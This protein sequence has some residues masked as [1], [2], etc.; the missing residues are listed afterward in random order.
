MTDVLDA[1]AAGL[2]EIARAEGNLDRVKHE[3]LD[4]ADQVETHES[5]RTVLTDELVPAARRQAIAEELLGGRAHQQTANVVSFV[6]GAG[7]AEDLVEIA[8]R[9][10]VRAAEGADATFAEVRSATP[11]SADQ[12]ARLAA[13]LSEKVGKKLDLRVVVD[14]SVVGG[15][16]ATIGDQVF[17]GS[18]RTKL[19]QLKT[20]L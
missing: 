14:P 11:L 15:L 19:D 9:M 6:I 4:V 8:R 5:L 17:D 2:V 13:A 10:A 20:L 1:Y 7:H 3:L 18:V 16:V 12:Q